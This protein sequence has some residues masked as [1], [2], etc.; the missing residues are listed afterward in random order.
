MRFAVLLLIPLCALAQTAPPPDCPVASNAAISGGNGNV[1]ISPPAPT[2][3]Y[4]NRGQ[5]C[6][7]WAV[8]YRADSG[9]SGYT[10]AFESSPGPLTP[11]G[12]VS[13]AGNT[14]TSSSSFGTASS[15]AAIYN[16]V[17][18]ASMT[19]TIDIPW[20]RVN[21]SGATG[22][23]NIYV[24]VEGWRSNWTLSGGG[25][26]GGGGGSGCTS[27]CPVVGTAAAGAPPSGD[28]VQIGGTDGTD[29]RALATDTSGNAKIVGAVAPGS[30]AP[31]PVTEGARND[32]GN[33]VAYNNFPDQAQITGSAVTGIK[34]VAGSMGK[35]IYVGHISV[36][37]AAGTTVSIEQGTTSSTPCDTSASTLAGPYQNTVA[38]ALDFTRDDPLHTT[39][40]GDDLCLIFGGSSTGGG[41][42]VYSQR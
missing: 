20:I 33:V 10:V 31:N 36:S 23:G 24:T 30:A 7:F 1:P 27:P 3:Y 15:G 19:T 40:T 11:S 13:F 16:S 37:L 28:P 22:T 41:A 34:V 9:L 38:L 32:S 39:T 21:T 18:T 4:D 25:S 29:I 12:F 14:V 5:M 2:A 26:G 42:L 8:S 35:L 17:S 6:T